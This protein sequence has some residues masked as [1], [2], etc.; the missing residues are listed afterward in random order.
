MTGRT[1]AVRTPRGALVGVDPANPLAGLVVFQYNP[2]EMTRRL[3]ARTAEGDDET[4]GARSEALRLTGAPIETIS[5]AVEVDATDQLADG[6]PQAVL[7][8]IHPQLAALEMLLYPKSSV[9]LENMAL[10][11]VGTIELVPMEAPLTLLV[12]GSRVLPVRLTSFSITEQA[13]DSQLNPIR[14]RADLELRV[15]SYSDLSVTSPGHH[16]FLAHQIAKE[17]MAT[18]SARSAAGRAVTG[19][20]GGVFR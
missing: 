1:D 7:L 3:V 8:G 14:A 9:V 16:L 20:I 4:G 12:W 5:L 19:G 18:L 11:A 2:D 6:D 15:L 13:Y 17:T 10:T